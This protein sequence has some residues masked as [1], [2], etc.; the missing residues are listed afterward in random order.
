VST[1]IPQNQHNMATVKAHISITNYQVNITQVHAP[2]TRG[3]V[4][5]SII[6]SHKLINILHVVSFAKFKRFAM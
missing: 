5:V 2:S 1:F 4:H 3:V 6:F